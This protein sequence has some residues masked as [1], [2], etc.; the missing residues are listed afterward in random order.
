MVRWEGRCRQWSGEKG[1]G[2]A[3]SGQVRRGMEMQAVF[4]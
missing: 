1:D 2:D 4:R 3:G